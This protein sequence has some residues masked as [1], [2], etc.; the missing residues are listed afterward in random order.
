MKMIR[1][2]SV[3]GLFFSLYFRDRIKST[4]QLGGRNAIWE[5]CEI[6]KSQLTLGPRTI[7]FSINN[8]T[9]DLMKKIVTTTVLLICIASIS[10]YAQDDKPQ[11]MGSVQDFILP[12]WLMQEVSQIQQMH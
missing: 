3:L 6:C 7:T 12:P 8:L 5:R 1:R 4:S 10:A 2:I 9:T 11:K